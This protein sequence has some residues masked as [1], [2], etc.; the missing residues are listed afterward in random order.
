MDKYTKLFLIAA[1]ISPMWAGYNDTDQ[2]IGEDIN[3]RLIL[4]VMDGTAFEDNGNV[5]QSDG[6]IA[7]F[8]ASL[9]S[10]H[11][12][13][14][15]LVDNDDDLDIDTDS[16]VVNLALRYNTPSRLIVSDSVS[17]GGSGS[18]YTLVSGQNGLDDIV[19]DITLTPVVAHGNDF[20]DYDG[21]TD[22]VTDGVVT[23]RDLNGA[24]HTVNM[25]MEIDV[26]AT[27]NFMLLNADDYTGSVYVRLETM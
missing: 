22:E 25:L 6:M 21:S 7:G 1:L 19:Y 2:T 12:T 15:T 13:T 17:G 10:F 16:A 24:E 11:D 23:L 18:G 9:D 5:N 26:D 20:S 14:F 27:G 3:E 4:Q 8:D